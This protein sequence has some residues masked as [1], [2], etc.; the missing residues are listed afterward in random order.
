MGIDFCMEIDFI[1]YYCLLV[2]AFYPRFI[3]LRV[4]VTMH[5]C[6]A[7]STFKSHLYRFGK[8]RAEI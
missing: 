1:F 8:K 2:K 3:L 6:V 5:A 4:F 7:R